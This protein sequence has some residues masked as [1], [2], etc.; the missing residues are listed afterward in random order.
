M[1]QIGIN[2]LACEHKENNIERMDFT[3]SNRALVWDYNV[4]LKLWDL[5]SFSTQ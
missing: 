1:K 2:E 3:T 4:S 5:P